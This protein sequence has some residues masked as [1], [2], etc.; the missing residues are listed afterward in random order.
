MNSLF[1]LDVYDLACLP[2]LTVE[3]MSPTTMKHA[4]ALYAGPVDS[5]APACNSKGFYTAA[6]LPTMAKKKSISLD[7]CE[8]NLLPCLH[9]FFTSCTQRPLWSHLNNFVAL[10]AD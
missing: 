4:L 9:F 3:V 6:G 8:E 2:L 7:A 1:L 10:S 5:F